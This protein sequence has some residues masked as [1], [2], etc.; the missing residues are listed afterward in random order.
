MDIHVQEALRIPNRHDLK[1]TSSCHIIVK[2][3][4][5]QNKERILKATKEKSNLLTKANYQNTTRILS[6]N[7]KSHESMD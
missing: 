6:R 3:P 5:V 2:M 7:S 1:K 4:R